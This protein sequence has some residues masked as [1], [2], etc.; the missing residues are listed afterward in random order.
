MLQQSL[1]V[2]SY[3]GLVCMVQQILAVCSCW[4]MCV[5]QLNRL[6][7]VWMAVY[8]VELFYQN[9]ASNFYCENQNYVCVTVLPWVKNPEENPVFQVHFT[10]HWQDNLVVSLHNFLATIFQVRF[11]TV[12]QNSAIMTVIHVTNRLL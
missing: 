8:T 3:S 6:Q 2:C 4:Y 9:C 12:S 1:A 10:R 5:V 7:H 11:I